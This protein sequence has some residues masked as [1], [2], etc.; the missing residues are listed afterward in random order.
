MSYYD[1]EYN[2]NEF[3]FFQKTFHKTKSVP[4]ISI[5]DINLYQ[6]KIRVNSPTTLRAIKLLGYN[7]SELEFLTLKDYIKRNPN[8]IG[9]SKSMQQSYYNCVEKLREERFNKIKILRLQLKNENENPKLM[10]KRSQSSYNLKKIYKNNKRGSPVSSKGRDVLGTTDLE[11]KKKILE[12]MR[13]KNETEILNKIQFELKRELARKKNEEKIEE[14]NIKLRKYEK[15]LYKK[16]KE[17][18]K[19]K[20]NKELELIKKQHELEIMQKE[21]NKKKY[22]EQM[23]KAKEEEKKEKKR[24]KYEKEKHIEEEKNRLLFQEKIN[25]MLSEKQQKILEKAKILQKKEYERRKFMEKKNKEQKELNLQKSLAKKE[26]IENTLR[27]LQQKNEE[28]RHNFEKKEEKSEKK[29]KK[30]EE[31][32]KK[33]NKLKLLNA[34]KKEEEIRHILENNEM[35]KQ[36]KID[37]YFEKQRI[38]QIKRDHMQKIN[39]LKKIERKK[40]KEKKEQK[41][42]DTLIKNEEILNERKNKII[43]NIKQKE[44]NTQQAWMKK[45]LS[46]E[47]AQEEHMEKKL[48]KEFRVKEIAQQKEN[49]LNDTRMKLFD[50]DQKVENFMREKYIINE[51]KRNI[52]LQINKQKELYNEKF[53]NLFNKKSID[54]QTLNSIKDMFPYNNQ[55]KELINEF[56][57]K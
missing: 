22:N 17:E 5:N 51:Q 46:A 11:N 29:R 36:Q 10:K 44:Y 48:E 12:R 1:N 26:Q 21:L 23:Q 40:N 14:Q 20:K 30:F 13:N 28:I 56:M 34:Q 7:I 27:N 18:E 45:K 43:N 42:K 4:N 38:L 32:L 9:I 6:E 52:T 49:K 47:K 31:M 57:K 39:D 54:E 16:R 3:P 35:I 8:L 25:K 37:N 24:L 53:E 19:I 33:Q 2:S 41:I 50:K 55:I 15:E